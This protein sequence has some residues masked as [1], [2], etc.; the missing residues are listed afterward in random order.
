M[1]GDSAAKQPGHMQEVLLHETSVA[2]IRQ[3]L[4][5]TTPKSCCLES[6]DAYGKRIKR[7]VDYINAHFD[8]EGLCKDLPQRLDDLIEAEGGRLKK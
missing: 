8:V 4:A 6:V 5:E 2:W 1:M 7:V 3:R